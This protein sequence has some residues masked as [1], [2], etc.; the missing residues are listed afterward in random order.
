MDIRHRLATTASYQLPFGKGQKLFP[1]VGRVTNAFV[2]G[3]QLNGVLSLYTGFFISPVQ[4]V[5]TLN[6]T[7]AQRPDLIAGC[8]PNLPASERTPQRWFNTACFATPAAYT[9]GNAGRNI[10]IG[11]PT[12]QLDASLFKEIAIAKDGGIRAQLRGE[13]F[14]VTN[15]PQFNN[16]SNVIGTA[17][18]ATISSAGS[19]GSFSRTQ[20][21]LQLALRILF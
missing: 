12:A 18:A 19:P 20:R 3:W 8:D 6:S 17:S 5:N 2:G 1:N 9:Y 11:P 16:P 13:F 15:T 10:L 4:G 14:N 21:Q 7:A